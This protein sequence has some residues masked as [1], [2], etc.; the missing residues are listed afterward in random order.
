MKN[1]ILPC[2]LAFVLGCGS[3]NTNQGA[4]ATSGSSSGNEQKAALLAGTALSGQ[5]SSALSAD[6][7]VMELTIA[8]SATLSQEPELIRLHTSRAAWVFY[9]N[10]GSENTSFETLTVKAQL[11]DT[12][13]SFPY[14]IANLNVVKARY[15]AIEEASQK[16]IAGDF[17]GLHA[18][19]DPVVMGPSK[20][21]DLQQYCTQIEP[22]YGK[23]LG[24]EFRG[25][26]FEKTSSGQEF[27]SLAGN[28]KREITDT[29]LNIYVDLTK[30]DL[31]GSLFSIK[32]AY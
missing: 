15:P 6:G 28:L 31:K 17:A 8:Q 20:A 29:P 25:F 19:F 4:P 27:L 24:F 1:I 32:F 26:A 16:L 9:N 13:I 21:A 10:L 14:T 30:Q 3:D 7:K 23:P 5:A 22:E 18:L 11:Q 2:L 12:T